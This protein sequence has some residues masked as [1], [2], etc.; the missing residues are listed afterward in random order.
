MRSLWAGFLSMLE[1]HQLTKHFGGVKAVDSVS[2]TINDGVVHG[3]IGPNG[4]GKTT[5]INLISGLLVH[6]SGTLKLDGQPIDDLEAHERARIGL[7]RTFQNLRIYPNL[8]VEQNIAVAASAAVNA[9]SAAATASAST[10]DIVQEAM[11]RFDLHDKRN[12][13]ASVLSY[14]HMRRLEIVRA[15]ALKPSVL[16]LDEPAAG[17][18]QQETEDLKNGLDW[19]RNTSRCAI[20]V[21]DHDLRFI[22]SVCEKITVMSMGKVLMT[23]LPSEVSADPRVVAAYLGETST[24]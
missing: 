6:S 23:G 3:L 8:T 10:I 24:D 14:G 5:L 9:R 7:A 22:M 4:A 20:L 18:N 19:I 17:M 21:I 11:N 12:L 15:L 16:M 2:L 1:L 13:Q